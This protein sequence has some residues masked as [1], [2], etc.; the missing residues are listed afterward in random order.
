VIWIN[1]QY[2]TVPP[3]PDAWVDPTGIGSSFALS[4]AIVS[5]RRPRRREF[6]DDDAQGRSDELDRHPDR[7][8]GK[9]GP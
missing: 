3:M 7:S 9:G 2:G 6:A 8:D 4:F 1:A 5:G